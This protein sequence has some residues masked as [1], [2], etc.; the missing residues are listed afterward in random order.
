[1][2]NRRYFE[3]IIRDTGFNINE[4]EKVYHLVHI[5]RT[6]FAE[7]FLRDNLT[8]KGG[9]ALNFI[10][11][12]LPRLSVDLDFNLTGPFEDTD[13]G[14]TLEELF[15]QIKA[16]AAALGYEYEELTSTAIWERKNL[17]YLTLQGSPDFVRIEV[18]KIERLPLL[19]RV[20]KCLKHPF[21]EL[22]KFTILTYELKEL[23]AMKVKS[24][25]DRGHPRDLFDLGKLSTISFER[26]GIFDLIAV[27]NCFTLQGFH[28]TDLIA[29]AE[30]VT[31]K[32]FQDEV[33]PFLK[34]GQSEELP[35]VKEKVIRFLESLYREEQP[36]HRKFLESFRSGQLKPELLSPDIAGKVKRHPAI[37]FWLS[38]R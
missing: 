14:F 33:V 10:Y 1:V 8:L 29:K 16:F 27:Y 15:G 24:L 31:D 12:D 5:L 13:M 30:A 3:K 32:D 25:F 26:E 22:G 35:D 21:P 34:S 38:L 37:L 23:V 17:R 18:D 11:F 36:A 2:P 28:L 9:T 19:G 20:E 7:P 4:I 6:I